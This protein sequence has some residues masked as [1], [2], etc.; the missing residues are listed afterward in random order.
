MD[1]TAKST[2]SV[3]NNIAL[4]TP[5]VAW[6]LEQTSDSG[7]V[8]GNLFQ[9]FNDWIVAQ[10]QRGPVTVSGNEMCGGASWSYNTQW[11]SGNSIYQ[12]CSQA[13]WANSLRPAPAPPF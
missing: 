8:Q 3:I 5:G 6:A 10:Y 1:T 12:T 4:G 11:A 13:P 7:V 2:S 9:N